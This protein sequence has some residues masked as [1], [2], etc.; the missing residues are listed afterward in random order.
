MGK[1]E[2]SKK[3][4]VI[5]GE[6]FYG[7]NHR[8]WIERIT[9]SKERAIEIKNILNRELIA[10]IERGGEIAYQNLKVN[11]EKVEWNNRQYFTDDMSDEEY[12]LFYLY[13]KKNPI[14]FKIFEMELS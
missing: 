1:R 4:Y 10:E 2:S 11:P 9:L 14:P 3:V 12:C 13:V 7:G 5:K 8:E 6:Y